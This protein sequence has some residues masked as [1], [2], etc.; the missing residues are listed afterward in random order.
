[1]TSS[2]CAGAGAVWP[3]CAA[4]AAAAA[5]VTPFARRQQHRHNDDAGS[6]LPAQP[7]LP[8]GHP[9]GAAP[10]AR[11]RL[12]FAARTELPGRWPPKPPSP[13]Q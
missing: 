6:G 2:Y 8:P 5:A 13:P 11:R 9:P 4:A 1:M 3:R 10:F 12:P 7:P